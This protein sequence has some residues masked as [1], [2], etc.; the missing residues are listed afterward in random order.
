MLRSIIILIFIYL[1]IK[2][3]KVNYINYFSKIKTNNKKTKLDIID[4][5]YE[6]LE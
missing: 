3:L 2:L 5:E 6:D 1:F 4:A